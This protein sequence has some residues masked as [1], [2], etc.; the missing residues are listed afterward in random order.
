MVRNVVRDIAGVGGEEGHTTTHCYPSCSK[1]EIKAALGI[2][3]E[4]TVRDSVPP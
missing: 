3:R 4:E 2:L 1:M